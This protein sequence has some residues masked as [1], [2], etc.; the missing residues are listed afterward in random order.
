MRLLM[1]AGM[2]L[3]LVSV[4]PVG[5]AAQPEAQGLAD[6]VGSGPEP[7]PFPIAW[8]FE[9][10]FLDPK[11]IEIQ[12]PDESK[13]RVFWYMVY[14][15]TNTSG[16]SQRFFPSIAM[17][18]EDLEVHESD[19]GISPLV[20]EA[21]RDRHEH[22]HPYM[23]HPTQ[24]IGSL[25]M[26]DDNARESVAIWPQFDLNVNNFYVYVSGLSGETLFVRNPVYDPAMPETKEIEGSDGKVREVV[27]NPKHF[28]LR[29]TLQIRYNL[30]GSPNL[31][32]LDD[33][34]RLGTEWIMR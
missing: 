17:V 28:T 15:V 19:I 33:V 31:R 4:S 2:C 34:Q 13:P 9:F 32:R 1:A 18:T 7:A 12:L 8:E 23:V 11:R 16:R 22:T 14:T 25:L 20:F 27:V 10:K 21:I 26:G 3:W 29:K 30:P 5:Q 6:L 24:A